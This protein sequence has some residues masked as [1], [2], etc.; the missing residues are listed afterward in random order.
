MIRELHCPLLCKIGILD[1]SAD[2]VALGSE[3]VDAYADVELECSHMSE[4]LFSAR[5]V[6]NQNLSRKN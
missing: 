2:S 1:I 3:C 4:D 5:Y 6:T